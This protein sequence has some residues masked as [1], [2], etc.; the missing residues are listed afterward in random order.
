MLATT[1]SLAMIDD[2]RIHCPLAVLEEF[3]TFQT[4]WVGAHSSFESWLSDI[5]QDHIDPFSG[6]SSKD[7]RWLRARQGRMTGSV[8]AGLLGHGYSSA[9]KAINDFVLEEVISIL[10]VCKRF[11]DVGHTAKMRRGVYYYI[12]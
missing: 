6:L 8:V 10:Q 1:S 4:W 2:A 3:T 9:N 5:S 11:N 7:S 12:N